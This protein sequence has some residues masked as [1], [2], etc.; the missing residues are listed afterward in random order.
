MFFLRDSFHVFINLFECSSYC[1]CWGI[2]RCFGEVIAKSATRAV[3]LMTFTQA[4]ELIKPS[5]AVLFAHFHLF[6]SPLVRAFGSVISDSAIQIASSALSGGKSKQELI[7]YC[8]KIGKLFIDRFVR[9]STVGPPFLRLS[10][11][12]LHVG[13]GETKIEF[14]FENNVY[15]RPKCL[16]VEWKNNDC[17]SKHFRRGTKMIQNTKIQIHFLRQ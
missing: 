9:R 1:E 10:R 2:F 5:I 7:R 15:V 4:G 13:I 8:I 6:S 3:G 12:S 11:E 16:S 14:R 17:F